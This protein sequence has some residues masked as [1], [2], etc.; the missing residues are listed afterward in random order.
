MRRKKS[1][2]QHTSKLPHDNYFR[3]KKDPSFFA[4]ALIQKFAS[5]SIMLRKICRGALLCLNTLAL[6]SFQMTHDISMV[7]DAFAF[8]WVVPVVHVLT[9]QA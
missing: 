6:R 4:L 5:S 7:I 8:L 1:L 2:L 3:N 9:H